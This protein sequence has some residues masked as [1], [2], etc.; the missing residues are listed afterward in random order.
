M[1]NERPTPAA[2][3]LPAGPPAHEG[4]V[5]PR[6]PA[7]PGA[8]A[9]LALADGTL[10]WGSGIGARGRVAGE[11]CFNTSITGYEEI[12]TDPSY[13]GQII[14]FTFPHIGNVG[15]NPED[16]ETGTIAARG[17]VVKQDLTEPSNWRAH[18]RL[19][20]WL[21]GQGISGIAGVDTRA[22]TIRIRD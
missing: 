10:L 13:A 20:A 22:L 3:R 5:A 18:Q 7:P 12:L 15:A 2:S 14:T 16:V 11:I 19:D 9:V 4:A 6:R 17:L 1:S 21:R 8:T